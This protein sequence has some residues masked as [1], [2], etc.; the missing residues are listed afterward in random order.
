M[1]LLEEFD[2]E[3]DS[4]PV[5]INDSMSMPVLIIEYKPAVHERLD[6]VETGQ[7]TEVFIRA[8]YLQH[9]YGNR[10]VLHLL[11]DLE[12]FHYFRVKKFSGHLRVLN[13]QPFSIDITN[14]EELLKHLEF[15]RNEILRLNVGEQ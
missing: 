10:E 11:T 1:A 7:L 4:S 13:Y 12:K 6:K 5:A 9:G 15:L 8:H 2:S 14:K 3:K